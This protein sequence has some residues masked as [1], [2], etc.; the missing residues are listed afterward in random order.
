[1]L[2]MQL[3]CGLFRVDINAGLI[4]L[5]VFSILMAVKVTRLG[6]RRMRLT[7]FVWTVLILCE[8]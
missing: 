4:N 3:V 5:G 6:K 7:S 2:R 1:M 8:C